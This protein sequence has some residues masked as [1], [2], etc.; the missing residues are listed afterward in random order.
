MKHVWALGL[1]MLLGSS[2]FAATEAQTITFNSDSSEGNVI[3]LNAT[4]TSGLPVAFTIISGPGVLAANATGFDLT[5]T[6]SDAV[7]VQADQAGDTT[8]LAATAVQK[9]FQARF[10]TQTFIYNG[11][12]NLNDSLGDGF[13]NPTLNPIAV[14]ASGNVYMVGTS[15][16]V[17]TYMATNSD[18]VTSKFDKNGV[19]VWSKKFDGS[20]QA[21]DGGYSILLNGSDVYVCG[22]TV[23]AGVR[24]AVVLKYDTDGNPS[25]SW[26]DTGK[27][28]GVRTYKGTGTGNNE[29]RIMALAPN[30]DLVVL[31]FESATGTG[32]NVLLLRFDSTGAFSSAWADKGDTINTQ[33]VRVYD[34]SGTTD[35]DA[36]KLVINAA[37]EIFVAATTSETHTTG[38]INLD[39]AI[40]KV[41]ADGTLTLLY[42]Y[43]NPMTGNDDY[44]Y[45]TSASTARAIYLPPDIQLRRPAKTT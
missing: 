22:W 5:F 44:L 43:D 8:Y 23:N 21:A 24:E 25:A 39:A 28:V 9:T 31:G 29:A 26:A 34:G 32:Q 12:D 35:D 13:S 2:A 14:D 1:V 7:V 37:G 18:I 10:A 45:M 38:G 40:I 4:A 42:A 36:H 30:G 6:G 41:T 17:Q 16:T 33:G 19:L 20:G 15:D 3:R 11:P 27:G